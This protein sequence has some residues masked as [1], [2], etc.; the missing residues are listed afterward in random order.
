[1]SVML[2]AVHLHAQNKLAPGIVA[3]RISSENGLYISGI[4]IRS[5]KSN[6]ATSTN[7]AGEFTIKI[8]RFP[9]TLEISHTGYNSL[10]LPVNETGAVGTISLKANITQLSE[11]IINTGYQKIKPNEANGSVVVIDNKMLNQ[12]TGINILKRLENVTSG[13]SFNPGYGNGNFQNK[14]NISVRGLSTINGPLDPLIVMDNFIYEGDINNINPNDIEN[15]TV[16]KD[17]AAA[18]IWGARAGN[19]VIILTTKKGRFN[20]KLKIQ[21]SA[22]LILTEKPDLSQLPDISI[23]DYIDVEEFLFNKG[24]FNSLINRKY[25][26][27]TPAVETLLKKRNGLITADEASGQLN[28]LKIVAGKEQFSKY[29]YNTA[30]IRQHAINLRGGT[31]NLAW[32]ISG[33]Y[34]KSIDNL[35]A[36]YEKMNFR[37][38]N[39][40]RPAKNI[41][42]DVGAWYTGSKSVSGKYTYN[43]VSNVNGR[44][45]PYLQYAGHDGAPLAVANVYRH[46]FVDTAGSGK[47]LDWKNY[48][49]DD[50]KHNKT[51]NRIEELVASI[52][53]DYQ[54]LKPL[55][56]N[57][58]YQFQ[59]QVSTGENLADIQSF[60][61]R[62]TINL[63]TQLDRS[64][65]MVKYMVPLGDIVRMSTA[66]RKSQNIRGQVNFNKSWRPHLVNAIAG[67]EVREVAGNANGAI[68]YGY[69]NDPLSF[70][71]VDFV[72]RYPT[73]ITGS[74]QTIS[75]SPALSKTINRFVAVYANIFY[76]LQEKYT[77][78]ASARKDGSNI[79]G[80]K[81][82]DK[83]KPLWSAG[84]GWALSKERFYSLNWMPELKLKLTWGYSG[85]VRFKPHRPS[86]S[87]FW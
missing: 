56:L 31:H 72:N 78:S 84:L 28:A 23:K 58:Q 41:Q 60:N 24:Y 79:L 14:T 75:G 36:A 38:N 59:K 44:H 7:E 69:Q 66:T 49:L 6:T 73:F 65:G 5:V 19:G 3:G 54:L 13:L 16:L 34:D 4:S 64:T 46:Q 74:S 62:N 29:F 55:H 70:S 35:D 8:S 12:Q 32:V 43:T 50:Y 85:N 17:A 87:L 57:V 20:Q 71:N 11:V 51:T 81:T 26:A 53:I 37:F 42:V 52:G 1:M 80:V 25:Q 86:F 76:A 45:V 22:D 82:N 48:P 83:W 68:F 30:V 15:I 9:D 77:L 61:T 63:F 67:A 10:W 18:A 47:L 39:T 21:L 2:G 40:Y 27:L 33:S